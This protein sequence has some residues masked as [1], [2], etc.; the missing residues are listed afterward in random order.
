[1][2]FTL[3]FPFFFFYSFNFFAETFHLS[4]GFQSAYC[5]WENFYSSCRFCQ[6]IPIA[7]SSCVSVCWLNF[8]GT[9][10]AEYFCIASW[11]PSILYF[12][13]KTEC[14]LAPMRSVDIVLA[15]SP[16]IWFSLQAPNSLLYLWFWCHLLSKLV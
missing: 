10:Y 1:M 5:L 3:K 7:L 2:I 4:F 16:S 6:V 9:L 14:C 13:C 8:P 12:V 11:R 15:G